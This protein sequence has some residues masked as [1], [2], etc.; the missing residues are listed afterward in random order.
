MNPNPQPTKISRRQVARTGIAAIASVAMP[1]VAGAAPAAVDPLIKLH[2]KWMK[3]RAKYQTHDK[4]VNE[5]QSA[6]NM[7]QPAK[8]A[9]FF[10][11]FVV[12]PQKPY[13][14]RPWHGGWTRDR[15]EV[16]AHGKEWYGKPGELVPVPP[17]A[18]RHAQKLLDQYAKFEAVWNKERE[19]LTFAEYDQLYTLS[20]IY[21]I[22]AK[23][24]KTPA[25]SRDGVRAKI[26]MIYQMARTEPCYLKM[27]AS[28]IEILQS[29]DADVA[30]MA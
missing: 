8:P 26:D 11:E 27:N 16:F 2:A 7:V 9:I 1:A 10:E 18:R 25:M 30:G 4:L 3:A 14:E 22:C 28:I 5:M 24:S 12:W 6:F 15:L 23:V 19:P 20:N 13:P 17:K 21:D 29:L